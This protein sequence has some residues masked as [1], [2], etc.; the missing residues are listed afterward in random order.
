M[1]A[2]RPVAGFL[3][4]F[5][6][7]F[8]LLIAPWPGLKEGY[9]GFLRTGGSLIFGSVGPHGL[10]WFFPTATLT[11]NDVPPGYRLPDP[12][13][14]MDI[15]LKLKS[16]RAPG[17]AALA[18]MSSQI[19]YRPTAFVLSLILASSIPW[20]RKWRALLWGLV[21]VNAYVAMIFALGIF[22]GFSQDTPVALFAWDSLSTRILHNIYEVVVLGAPGPYLLPLPIWVLVTFRRGDWP[23]LIRRGRDVGRAAPTPSSPP[24]GRR[25]T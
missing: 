21:W 3:L 10:V 9:A 25:I 7:A 20:P 8:V 1:S 5:L 15:H 22:Y 19:G 4:R 23:P 24:P 12:D 17:H 13:R 11:P 16:R 18:H 2:L 6:V 14:G